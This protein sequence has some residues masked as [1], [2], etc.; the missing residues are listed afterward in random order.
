MQS[1]IKLQP[2]GALSLKFSW[3]EDYPFL[4]SNFSIC[5]KRTRSL[6]QKLAKTPDLLHMYGKI[7][8]DQECKGFIDK[9][10]NFNTKQAHYIPH[11]AVRKDSTTTPV[12]IVYDC[13]CRQS[14]QQPSLND[15]L[16]VGLP[17]LNH[18]CAILLRFHLYVYG[19]TVDIEKAF[20]HVQLDES[21]RDYTHFL[22]LSNLQDPNSAFQP[23]RF[24]VVLFGA[25]C[26]PFMFN[27]AITFHL[28]QYTISSVCQFP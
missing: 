16:H 11:R 8:A 14:S 1:S 3:K 21:D 26:S 10:N 2:E 17:F 12:R 23:Y 5:A 19:F 27:A 15:C 20:L 9:V 28:Q 4:L 25:S 24:K 13:S 22:W 18:L 7:T 6:T